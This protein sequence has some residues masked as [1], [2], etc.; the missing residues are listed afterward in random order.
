MECIISST[1]GDNGTWFVT[2]A[3]VGDYFHSYAASPLDT[4][5]AAGVGRF[6]TKVLLLPGVERW[7]VGYPTRSLVVTST[8]S[9]SLENEWILLWILRLRYDWNIRHLF[10]RKMIRWYMCFIMTTILGSQ[11]RNTLPAYGVSG[12]DYC[13]WKPQNLSLSVIYC[14]RQHFEQ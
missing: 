11:H 10:S 6:K 1:H 2:P 3:I 13:D 8:E 12:N 4:G 14:T 5:C 9:G 7:I